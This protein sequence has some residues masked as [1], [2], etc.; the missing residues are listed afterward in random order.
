MWDDTAV[1]EMGIPAIQKV[2]GFE[3]PNINKMAAEGINFMRMYTEPSC[4][5]SRAAVIT[6]RKAVRSGMYSVSFPIESSGMDA[7]EVT[8]AAVLGKAGYATA[9]YGKWHLGDTKPS[10]PTE[11]GF[12][13]AFWTPYNQVPSMWVPQ[14]ELMGT[15]T[16][17]FKELYPKDPYDLDNS[18][19]P[20]GSVWTLEATKGGPVKEWGPPPDIRN[21]WKI[22]GESLTRTLA[23]A[24]KTVAAKKPFFVSWWPVATAFFPNPDSKGND[25]TNKSL[26]G[27][28]FT[29]IAVSNVVVN[30]PGF[31]AAGEYE[32]VMNTDAGIYGGSNVGNNGAVHSEPVA[33]QAF[34]FSAPVTLPP[35]GMVAFKRRAG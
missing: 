6:G 1:G 15:V 28:T 10:Y 27:D 34:K 14:G 32:E 33:W 7:S 21:Y 13:E 29:R 22:D 16:G 25:S 17:L 8:T 5:P 9:F 3:T 35:L 19:Q 4:T 31:P 23:F 2:R 20:R 26:A 24:K 18:W 12:D 30:G 11:M